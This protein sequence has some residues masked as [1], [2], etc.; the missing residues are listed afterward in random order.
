M[1]DTEIQPNTFWKSLSKL[2][3]LALGVALVGLFA[4]WVRAPLHDEPGMGFL[5]YLGVIALFYIAYRFW[6]RWRGQLLWSLRNRLIVAYMFIA[7]VPVILLLILAV[8]AAQI[9]YSQLG[10]YLLYE[11]I[12]DRIELLAASS[13]HVAAAEA[14][15]PAT[16]DEAALEQALKST[17]RVGQRRELPG[18]TMNFHVD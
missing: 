11:D 10:A 12:Q 1:T 2:D 9:I 18:L 6:S 15:L 17:V 13:A 4:T 7:F 8:L 3:W 14:S 5:R 16:L